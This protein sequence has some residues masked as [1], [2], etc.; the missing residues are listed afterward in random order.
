MPSTHNETGLTRR[1]VLTGAAAAG[2]GVVAAGTLAACG[3]GGDPAGNGGPGGS[4]GPEGNGGAT[5]GGSGS[6]TSGGGLTVPVAE[7]PVG[8]A[9]IVGQTI[10]S[11]PVAGQFR[12]FS[13]VC[14]HE[15]CLIS[16]VE[17]A[18]VECT[19]HGSQFSA[20]DG[21]VLRGPAQRPL[22]GQTVTASGDTLTIS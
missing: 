5:S 7:V 22:D 14:T 8:G 21:S 16:R 6:A 4:G 20:V 18:T 15:F 12:A 1:G 19:C 11:Q 10:V 9:V 13:A 17:A 3:D 2:M